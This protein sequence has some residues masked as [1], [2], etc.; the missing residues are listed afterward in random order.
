MLNY[1]LDDSGQGVAEYA[2]I[3]CLASITAMAAASGMGEKAG[4]VLA[5]AAE[6]ISS[7][8]ES[9]TFSYTP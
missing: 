1:L 3:L 9:A 6:S 5:S 7:E 8:S 2:L 4:D